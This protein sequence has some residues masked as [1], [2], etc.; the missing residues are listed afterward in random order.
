MITTLV[1]YVSHSQVWALQQGADVYVAGRSNRSKVTFEK[2]L[3][4]VLDEVP[5]VEAAPAPAAS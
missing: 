2:E 5:E 1:S 3:D 4:E